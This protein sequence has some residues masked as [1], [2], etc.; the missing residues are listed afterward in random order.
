M[1]TFYR[2]EYRMKKKL[3]I[4]I[5]ILLL[6]ILG[7]N[8]G[9]VHAQPITLYTPYTGL[10][11]TPGETLTYN[12][13]VI[14]DGG[15][16]QNMTFEAKGLPKGWES[17]IIAGGNSIQQLSVRPGNEQ[18]I[19]IEVNVPLEVEKDDYRFELVANANGN[20][21]SLP[22]LVTV[23]EEGTFKTELTSEQPNM[24][25]HADSTF[26]YTAT[27]K[28]YTAEQQHYSLSSNAPKGW[29]VQFQADGNS[30]TSVTLEPNETKDID[31]EIQPAENVKEETYTIPIVASA[32]ST[33]SELELEAA[34]TG[35]Y[36]LNLTTPDETLSTDVTAGRSRVVDLVVE[37]NGT[38][39]LTDIQLTAEA[40]SN[41]EAT[42]SQDRIASLPT[43]EKV[44][45]QATINAPD[46]AISG[47]YVTTFKVETAEVSA[48]APFR[49]SV[50]TST[51]WGIVG[52]GI[53]LLVIGGLYY[54]FKKY[55]RR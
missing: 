15:S 48:D 32:G 29:G 38:A 3:L 30:V 7:F 22:F 53:I 6:G 24:E 18:Q 17:S 23:S 28:N 4:I 2:E 50:K 25:G 27:L 14:N 54:I 41:W 26:S 35:T 8:H 47:D 42:F 52:I 21:A 37:N 1:R 5:P 51:L 9:K 13:D 34:I 12:V 44:T 33:N 49:V 10:S 19:T 11:V 43:G 45:V 39:D 20:T 36:S 31:I 16:I 46:D 40:P 55:G